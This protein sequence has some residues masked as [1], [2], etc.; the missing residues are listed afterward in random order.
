[1]NN[2]TKEIYDLIEE[3]SKRIKA[4]PGGSIVPE[5]DFFS[6]YLA[7]FHRL[8]SQFDGE[9][10]VRQLY[11]HL[12]EREASPADVNQYA[13]LLKS[14]KL[15]K[16]DL[17][18]IVGLSDECILKG[19]IQKDPHVPTIPAYSLLRLNG[20][21]FVRNS[22]L[23]ILGRYPDSGEARTNLELL[24]AGTPK[25]GILKG[26]I[27]SEEGKARNVS[28][29]GLGN[30]L[31]KARVK[32]LIKKT[33]ILGKVGRKV[34]YLLNGRFI[35]L[36]NEMRLENAQLQAQV[37]HLQKQLDE[38]HTDIDGQVELTDRLA[39]N[40]R[41]NNGRL[42]KNELLYSQ[43]EKKE[44]LLMIETSKLKSSVKGLS[45]RTVSAGVPAGGVPAERPLPQAEENSYYAIDYFDFENRF[46][47]SR[48]NIKKAQTVYLPYFQGKTHVLDLG[49]G[50]G[51][52][53]ELLVENGIGVTG[54]DMFEPY[55]EYMKHRNLPAVLDDAIRYLR[56]QESTDGIF[57]GQVVE[58]L[59]INQI[60]ELCEV[61]YEKLEEG[62]CLIMETPNPMTLAVFTHAFYMDPSH[63]N[64]VH[65]FTL[66]YICEKA[67]FS[68]ASILFTESSRYPVSIPE[69]KG[70]DPDFAEFNKAM[71]QLSE[72][73]Y[74][75]Q[76]YAVIA[77][78]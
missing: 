69:L 62:C 18:C 21:L 10:Y 7:D 25:A 31:F 78:K 50:R 12:L 29:E 5:G 59:T 76:D 32:N 20:D 71:K 56:T 53:T 70:D 54:V 43:L 22:F 27:T 42:D 1:M 37:A 66:Q 72:D 3:E 30:A 38:L 61:A 75:S 9:E 64:P 49:C 8:L 48:E 26:L 13:G 2:P 55:V 68:E 67:G 77:R 14:G 60:I 51:E 4:Q 40:I 39:E 63:K 46:R 44:E 73:M 35:D 17:F 47:G 33:P 24:N 11:Q 74:G 65:P 57:L 45:A 52:F 28:V 19:M 58:H 6:P 36:N 23:W 41:N 34:N 16:D 15:S